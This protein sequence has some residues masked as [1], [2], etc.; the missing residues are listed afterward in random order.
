M[1]AF[2]SFTSFKIRYLDI[3]M[4]LKNVPIL[5]TIMI[6]ACVLRF[7]SSE[8]HSFTL[9]LSLGKNQS[10]FSYNSIAICLKQMSIHFN[11]SFLLDFI[12]WNAA[13]VMDG[14]KKSMIETKNTPR[15][16]NGTKE[17]LNLHFKLKQFRNH[18]KSSMG[19]WYIERKKKPWCRYIH[20]RTVEIIAIRLLNEDKWKSSANNNILISLRP[21][22]WLPNLIFLCFEY[23]KHTGKR[24][25]ERC[26]WNKRG[27]K[28]TLFFLSVHIAKSKTGNVRTNIRWVSF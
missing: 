4:L 1:N 13:M 8:T 15:K 21:L 20:Q 24:T 27:K 11:N 6:L 14:E 3:L 17:K 22:N 2:L 9:S 18:L 26:K 5:F 25:R 7:Q 23:T 28:H 12:W 16:W 10:R 19:A